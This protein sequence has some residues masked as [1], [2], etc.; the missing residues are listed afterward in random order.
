MGAHEL[1]AQQPMKLSME[2]CRDMALTT[3]E[4]LKQADNSLRQAELDDKIAATARLP[5]IEGS[6]TGAYVLPDIEMT[7][8]ELAMRGTYMAGLTLTQPIYTGGKISAGRQM[9]RLGRQIADQQL[10]MTRMDVL[11]DADNAYWSYIAVRR[12]VRMLE[13]YSTQM[14]TI[15]K[16]TSSAVAAGMAIENDLLRIEAKRTEI[17]YQLQ[18]AR[19]GADLCRMALCNVIGAPLDTA[20]EPTD[21]TFNIESPTAMSLDIARRPEVG[22]LE[23]QIDVNMQRIRDARSEMLPT[24]GLSAGY[25]YY[26]NIKLNGFADMGN[27]TTVPYTQEFRDVNMQRIRDA[28]SEMLPTVG[29]SAGYSYYGNIKLNGF[30]DMGNGTTVPYTQEFRDGIGIAMLAVKIPIFHWGESRKKLHKARY[31]LDNSQLELQ[32]N[33]RLMSIEAQ[34]AV[35]N[36]EDGYRMIHTAESGLRQAEENLR[37]MRN[38]YAAAMSPL[39]DL[40]DAQSQWQQAQSNLIEAQTQYMIYRTDYLRATGQLE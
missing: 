5:K 28:R 34:Q 37:V 15:Y 22:L 27:G 29:L 32:R 24:V 4:E 20:I 18:R 6:A 8:M 23:K 16:Q 19:N 33:M 3:S 25:S 10:R 31:E 17:E 35:Q 12:K 21:T 14:D 30:A 9:A 13:S 1:R 26:G 36:V 11:V 2:Q 7:G 39:T 40:L 38:R